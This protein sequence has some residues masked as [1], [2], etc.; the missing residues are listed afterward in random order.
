MKLE[1]SGPTPTTTV[2]ASRKNEV[3][4][5]LDALDAEAATL[6][7]QINQ[8]ES[9]LNTVTADMIV[10]GVRMMEIAE[11]DYEAWDAFVGPFEIRVKGRDRLYRQVAHVLFR[12]RDGQ[13]TTVHSQISRMGA[14][15]YVACQLAQK[16]SDAAKLKAEIIKA[17][18]IDGLSRRRREQLTH[19][20]NANTAPAPEPK[21]CAEIAVPIPRR[22][23]VVVLLPDGNTKVVPL[24]LAAKVF[25]QMGIAQ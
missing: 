21:R 25:E 18:C 9:S 1:V 7:G 22:P 24:E 19:E 2:L 12:K 8:H 23:M 10:T 15:I 13:P 20:R 5:R 3:R 6:L 14:A 4:R 11:T 16:V 17:G